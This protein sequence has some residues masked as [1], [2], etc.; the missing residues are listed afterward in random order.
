MTPDWI[1]FSLLLVA[2]ILI[3]FLAAWALSVK[4][5]PLTI[6]PPSCD[7][8][9]YATY[10]VAADTVDGNPV[11]MS[12][13]EAIEA[14]ILRQQFDKLKSVLA[15]CDR[16]DATPALDK[17]DVVTVTTTSRM[18]KSEAAQISAAVRHEQAE[19]KAFCA[20][21]LLQSGRHPVEVAPIYGYASPDSMRKALARYGYR[22]NGQPKEAPH[23]PD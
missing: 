7:Q 12:I 1:I 19:S 22:S 15:E 3:G 11:V 13:P 8:E 21:T 16:I 23:D 4:P 6:A 2:F 14:G 10:A 20:A 9:P 18:T 17:P 5:T